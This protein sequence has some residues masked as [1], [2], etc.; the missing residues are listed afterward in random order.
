MNKKFLLRILSFVMMSFGIIVIA[1][2]IVKY[3]GETVQEQ[4][5]KEFK[6]DT[7][8]QLNSEDIDMW[9]DDEGDDG[10]VVESVE[11]QNANSGDDVDTEL[12]E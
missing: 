3:H 1:I 2:G 10:V 9:V 8:G 4:I 11:N 12:N 5:L 6:W 7:N